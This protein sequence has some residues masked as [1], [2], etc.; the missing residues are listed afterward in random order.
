MNTLR[1][2]MLSQ[3]QRAQLKEILESVGLA[4]PLATRRAGNAYILKILNDEVV[5]TPTSSRSRSVT[6][7]RAH[8]P[9]AASQRLN[10]VMGSYKKFFMS[11]VSQFR[12]LHTWQPKLIGPSA[13]AAKI[14]ALL[15]YIA[16]GLRREQHTEV[17]EL[18]L[19]HF[20]ER[21]GLRS[22]IEH[23]L[24]DIFSSCLHH[25][26]SV[27]EIDIF[28]RVVHGFYDATD[29]LFLE[30]VKHFMRP[31]SGA[32]LKLLSLSE[33]DSVT[34]RIFGNE[35]Q[36]VGE[37]V[38]STL[39]AEAEHINAAIDPNYY[40]YI[41]LW[42]FHHQRLEI[43]VRS[44]THGFEESFRDSLKGG[45]NLI[46]SYID[47][48]I[49]LKQAKK[50][51]ELKNRTKMSVESLE[52]EKLVHTVLA[53]ACRQDED[54]FKKADHLMQTVLMEEPFE[55][56]LG[57]CILARNALLLAVE[58][59]H[60]I[61]SQLHLFCDTIASAALRNTSSRSYS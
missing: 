34:N 36:S 38:M 45:G 47:S 18:I 57:E 26:K 40:V 43:D 30:Y 27:M 56:D 17:G 25:R 52:L 32:Q 8:Q 13:L 28:V 51:T 59:N 23:N 15:M 7:S 10:E 46:D 2:S 60:D 16:E 29:V 37:A 9:H 20:Q 53:D 22:L 6:P 49:S 1:M 4:W 19:K 61:E 55:G 21:L 11:Y 24:L 41:S 31:F 12:H 35:Q 5:S 54:L 3:H 44:S 42:V 33:L 48:I 14:D 39:R 58:K 50:Q